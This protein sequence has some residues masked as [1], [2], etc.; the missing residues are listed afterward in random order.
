MTVTTGTS[1][2][3]KDRNGAPLVPTAACQHHSHTAYV[4]DGSINKLTGSRYDANVLGLD[5]EG[6]PTSTLDNC[7]PPCSPVK[8][9]GPRTVNS[10]ER[11]TRAGASSS[12]P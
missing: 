4:T 5:P 10:V 11:R 3:M 7:P 6:G 9:R 1:Q 2:V 12:P 8:A